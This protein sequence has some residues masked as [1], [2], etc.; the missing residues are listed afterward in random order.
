MT[1]PVKNLNTLHL[2]RIVVTLGLAGVV[3][4]GAT[5]VLAQGP[6]S[7]ALGETICTYD[8]SGDHPSWHVVCA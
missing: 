3:A 4:L 7:L 5:P 2:N 6:Q 8:M 1:R